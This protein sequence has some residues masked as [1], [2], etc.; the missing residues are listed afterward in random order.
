MKFVVYANIFPPRSTN[1]TNTV[2]AMS[3]I[4][5]YAQDDLKIVMHTSALQ[6][7]REVQLNY[8]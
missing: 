3:K 1:T 7:L 4:L 5:C 8:I 2:L 6:R